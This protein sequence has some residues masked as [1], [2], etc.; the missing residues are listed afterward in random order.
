MEEK[1]FEF[2]INNSINSLNNSNNTYKLKFDISDSSK[3]LMELN[4]SQVEPLEQPDSSLAN[5]NSNIL[6]NIDKEYDLLF[7]SGTIK[8]EI[9]NDTNKE[10]YSKNNINQINN[11]KVDN[12]K[13]IDCSSFSNKMNL[14]H[15]N[16]EIK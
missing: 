12:Y 2:F 9:M 5:F 8:I 3:K 16:N 6:E 10:N 11:F 7:N 14:P 15:E 13:E 4:L 1:Y